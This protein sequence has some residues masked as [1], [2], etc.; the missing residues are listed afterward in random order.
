VARVDPGPR[1]DWFEPGAWDRLRERGWLVRPDSDR[2]G[3]RLD[4]PPLRRR[5]RDELPSEGLVPGAIQVPP[6]GRPIVVGPD[7]P[8]TGGY[9]VIGVVREEDL[10]VLAQL[11]PGDPLRLTD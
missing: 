7:G 10:G 11:R 6:D 3:I 8:V 4:G 5:R 9:P 1:L 2:V